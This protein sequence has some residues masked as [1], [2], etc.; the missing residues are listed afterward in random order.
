MASI[1]QSTSTTLPKGVAP[2]RAGTGNSFLW[3]RLHSLTGIVPV[4]LFLL[5]HFLSNVRGCQ[6]CRLPTTRR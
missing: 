2:L 3:R 4:G 6:R 1:A 5:E